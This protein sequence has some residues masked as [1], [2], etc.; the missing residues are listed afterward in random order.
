M[1]RYHGIFI[2]AT[3]IDFASIVPLE[4]GAAHL[5]L[6]FASGTIQTIAF[7]A[8]EEAGGILDLIQAFKQEVY[9]EQGFGLP[10]GLVEV[11]PQAPPIQNDKIKDINDNIIEVEFGNNQ[12]E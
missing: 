9:Y 7:K 1:I 2:D 8:L 5:N 11:D 10:K 6:T 4:D 3:A 12:P